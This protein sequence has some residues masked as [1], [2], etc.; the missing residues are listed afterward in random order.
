MDELQKRLQQMEER[1]QSKNDYNKVG[2]GWLKDRLY[3]HRRDVERIPQKNSI[4]LSFHARV[5]D[6]RLAIEVALDQGRF[7]KYVS[8]PRYWLECALEQ[9][10]RGPSENVT[11]PFQ[12]SE[13]Q[14]SDDD[15]LP[16]LDEMVRETYSEWLKLNGSKKISG[17]LKSAKNSFSYSYT[18]EPW[19]GK[20]SMNRY[21]EEAQQFARDCKC[22]VSKQVEAIRESYLKAIEPYAEFARDILKLA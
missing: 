11:T 4:Y 7:S 5:H 14:Y 6:C 13:Y 9:A 10:E 2:I 8:N 3:F 1:N 19:R 22:D 15:N 16:N 17:L 18:K 12:H 20:S 21:L